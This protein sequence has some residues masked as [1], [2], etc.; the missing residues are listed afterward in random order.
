MNFINVRYN[1]K[2]REDEI[3]LDERLIVDEWKRHIS[4]KT[5]RKGMKYNEPE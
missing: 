5:E 1:E 4:G 3:Y 2:R